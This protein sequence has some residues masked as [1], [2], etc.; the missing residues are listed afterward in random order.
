[1]SFKTKS[2][3]K[4]LSEEELKCLV[5]RYDKNGDGKLNRQEL[6][7]AFK[8]MGIWFCGLRAYQA[9]S[10]ADINHDGLIFEDEMD[11]LVEFATKWGFTL[12]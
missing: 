1:M 11:A 4:P 9:M 8:D 2:L 10:H 6:K 12:V 7:V 3:E 5:K